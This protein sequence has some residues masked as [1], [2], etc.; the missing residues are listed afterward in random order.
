MKRFIKNISFFLIPPFLFL[1][2][3]I[4]IFFMAKSTGEFNPTE[5]N[6]E[7]Q[8][9]NKKC[10]IG[11]A[12][13]EQ[14]PY[15][16]LINANHYQAPIISLGSSRVMQFRKAIFLDEFYNCG[17][18]VSGNYNEYTNFLKN[19]NYN[20]EI[21]ILGLDTWVFNDTWNANCDEYNSF[22]TIEEMDRK[23]IPLMKDIFRDWC[24]K[25]WT[26]KDLNLYPEN[27]G[28]N[29]RVKD[30]GFMYD[31]SYYYGNIYRDPSTSN[32][33]GFV[34]T[35]NRI[36]SEGYRFEW[37]EHIDKDTIKQL[38]GLLSYC[39]ENNIQ[40]IGFLPPFAPSIFVLMEKSGNYQYIYE[41]APACQEMFGKYGYEFYDYLDGNKLHVTDEYF[42]DGFHGG[43]VVYARILIDM[44][45]NNEK[46]EKYIDTVQVQE[47]IDNVPNKCLI[48]NL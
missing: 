38:D 12:Y 29:G 27:I 1:A 13:N 25:K 41:I 23:T 42:I 48:E 18:A 33:Y 30:N 31:G 35:K 7:I 17:G 22:Q 34:D 3:P 45:S 21:V 24:L 32:D 8:R 26:T 15:Y 46:L 9:D 40:V 28:F 10:I 5:K 47:L 20:P 36:I 43:D 4:W 37:G 19:L 11:W 14:T 39:K 2:L 6:A 16:K 44:A